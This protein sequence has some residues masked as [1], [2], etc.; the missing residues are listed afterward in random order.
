MAFAASGVLGA[1]GKVT[2][3]PD[4]SVSHLLGHTVLA[5]VV[6]VGGIWLVQKLW[7]RN[8][9][10]GSRRP[11]KATSGLTVVSRHSL[12]KDQHLAVIRW[13]GREVLVGISGSTI[14][15]FDDGLGQALPSRHDVRDDAE[16][17]PDELVGAPSQRARST[18]TAALGTVLAQRRSGSTTGTNSATSNG[19]RPVL[20]RLRDLTERS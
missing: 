8:R 3:V 4:V 11:G 16:A 17:D 9:A 7:S 15:F 1:T 14:S 10:R 18:F 2:T 13:G 19:P 20:D 12:G 5:L 6:I